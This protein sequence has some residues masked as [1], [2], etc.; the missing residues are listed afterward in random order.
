LPQRL[1]FLLDARVHY[2]VLKIRA[3]FDS[4]LG[5]PLSDSSAGYRSHWP[6]RFSLLLSESET[7]VS[8]PES[9]F[10]PS[11]PNNVPRIS[12]FNQPFHAASSSTREDLSFWFTSQYSIHEHSCSTYENNRGIGQP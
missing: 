5:L 6:I 8:G 10:A 7:E 3:V 1:F 9:A 11:G 12:P 4:D 2:A